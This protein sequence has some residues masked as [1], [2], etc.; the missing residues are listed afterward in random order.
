MGSQFAIAFDLIS[1]AIVVLMFFAGWRRGLAN[2]VLGFAAAIVAF[3]AAMLLSMPIAEAVYNN[4]VEEPLTEKIDEAVDNSFSSLSL[5]SFSEVEFESVF[6]SGTAADEIELDYL[7]RDSAIIDLTNVDFSTIGLN[8]E[9]LEFLG[10]EP[11]FNL[12]SVNIKTAEFSKADVEKY[13]LGKL[14]VSQ[15]IS[16]SMIEKGDLSE[17]NKFIE[18]VD[19]YIPGKK[20]L[21]G[22]DSITVSYVRKLVLG[23]MDSK[24][25]LRDTVM[26]TFVRPNCIIVIRTAAFVLI[27]A[28]VFAIIRFI[29]SASKLIDKIPV[30]GDINSF[31]GGIAGA[32]EGILIVFIFCLAARL[33]VSVL[34]G[35]AMI[36]NQ[37]TIDKTFIFK[38]IYEFDFLNF[39]T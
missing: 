29:A 1:V 6:I 19:S 36:F 22:S 39:L 2:M 17:F 7:G 23:M 3:M 16:V 35:N 21:I 15:F 31:L 9:D 20:A 5:N 13:G 4:Y 25:S 30:V 18:L 12:S 27:Y 34:D 28:I 26:T 8:A 37:E 14:A 38:R 11:T 24:E 32:V 10:L 33:V